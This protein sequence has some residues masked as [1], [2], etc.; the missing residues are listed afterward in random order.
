MIF[1]ITGPDT[2][3][4]QQ[5]LQALKAKFEQ[6]V[7]ASGLNMHE[8][9]GA[10]LKIEELAHAFDAMPLLARR[11]FVVINNVLSNKN[12][13]LHEAILVRLKA[14]VK[15]GNIVV[16]VEEEPPT[17]KSPLFD[18][19]MSNAIAQSFATLTG[20]NL[21]RWFRQYASSLGREVVPQAERLLLDLHG[22][23]L[24][25]LVSDLKK[26]DAFLPLKQT[27]VAADV[28]ALCESPYHEDIFRLVDA[29]LAGDTKTGVM[30]LDESLANGLAPLQLVGLLEKQLAVLV[31]ILKGANELSG[32]HPFVFKKLKAV[33]VHTTLEKVRQAYVDLAQIDV[34]LKSSTTSPA[35]LLTQFLIKQQ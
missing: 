31:A 20:A 17:I 10:T 3:R 21:S 19:L 34:T 12:V 26:L 14:D 4:V 30:L 6:E 7:D 32:V 24:W 16:F 25:G 27:I 28:T 13:K 2:F 15:D 29:M 11:R 8:V 18:W 23:D 35:V 22:G 1:L 5:K 9:K 33:A